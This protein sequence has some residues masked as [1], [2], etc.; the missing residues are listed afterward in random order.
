M[1]NKHLDYHPEKTQIIF[2][3]LEFYVPEKD[4]EGRRELKANPYKEGHFLI[5]GTFTKYFPMLPNNDKRN[6]TK[7][8]WIWDYKSDEK[9]ML[10]DI[11]KFIDES[12][13]LIYKSNNQAELF[14]AGIGIQRA[15]IQYLFARSKK[16]KLKSESELFDIFYKGRFL[17]FENIFIPLFKNKGN[18][19]KTKSTHDIIKK[20][21]IETERK[22]STGIW[23]QFDSKEYNLIKKRNNTEVADL[24]TIYKKFIIYMH[25]KEVHERYSP[26]VIEDIRKLLKSDDFDFLINCYKEMDDGWYILKTN[27]DDRQ[28]KILCTIENKIIKKKAKKQNQKEVSE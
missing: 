13:K 26:K 20:F 28:K 7:E 14:Y 15:D 2:F 17:D 5:G 12:W 27:L 1:T 4:R 23:E 11:L 21:N 25:F 16:Y 24:L 10:A 18:M 6:V 19:L 9:T 8:F 3:D 22:A